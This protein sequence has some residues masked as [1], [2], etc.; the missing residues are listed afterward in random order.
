MRESKSWSKSVV[1][2]SKVFRAYER[3]AKSSHEEQEELESNQTVYETAKSRQLAFKEIKEM[4]S[5][6]NDI[7]RNLFTLDNVKSEFLRLSRS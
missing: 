2:I 5:E 3:A 4:I 1:E 6:T 7:R